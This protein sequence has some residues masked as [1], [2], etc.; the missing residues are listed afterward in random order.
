MINTITQAMARMLIRVATLSDAHKMASNRRPYIFFNRAGASST[1]G[2]MLINYQL[3]LPV[4]EENNVY[5]DAATLRRLC[6]AGDVVIDE[7]YLTGVSG[8]KCQHL[9]DEEKQH[10]KILKLLQ[11]LFTDWQCATYHI[12]ALSQTIKHNA[13]NGSARI[14]FIAENEQLAYEIEYADGNISNPERVTTSYDSP[15][16]QR[17][18]MIFQPTYIRA[19][20]SCG[21]VYG[22]VKQQDLIL[23]N[24][25]AIRYGIGVMGSGYVAIV[26]SIREPRTSLTQK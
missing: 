4:L 8:Y 5:I 23:W 14:H 22:K 16:K 1:D 12:G 18:H 13:L 26:A 20:V 3:D 11:S 19:L 10:E 25:D 6:A 21:S 24:K 2:S 9:Y 17:G 7:S 15:I